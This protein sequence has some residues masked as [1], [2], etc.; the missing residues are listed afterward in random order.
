MDLLSIHVS[1]HSCSVIRLGINS[2]RNRFT[3]TLKLCYYLKNRDRISHPY[4]ARGKTVVL[5]ILAFASL[6]FG[7]ASFGEEES[8]QGFG[9]KARRKE[10]TWKTKA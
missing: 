10:T 8:V 2:L 3:N 4:K 7:S 1:L 9:G 5:Y 6:P